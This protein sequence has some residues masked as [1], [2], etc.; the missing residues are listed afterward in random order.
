MKFSVSRK[1]I[2]AR[3]RTQR[4]KGVEVRGGSASTPT[5][6]GVDRSYVDSNLVTLSTEQVIFAIK[7]FA[8][9]VKIGGALIKY[10]EDLNAYVL[11]A[12][13]LVEGGVASFATPEGFDPPT[14][15][16]AVKVD[17]KT[18]S[19]ANGVLE[20]ISGVS[21]GG[22]DPDVDAV[23][24]Y[25]LG[26]DGDAGGAGLNEEELKAYLDANEYAQKSDIPTSLPAS[27]VYAWAKAATKPTYNYSEIQNTPTIP[28]VP[29]ELP[30]PAAL[31]WTA[32]NFNNSSKS[33]YYGDTQKT[34][35][36]PTSVSHLEGGTLDG[37]LAVNGHIASLST[38]DERL[39]KNIRDFSATEMLASMGGVYEYEY[40]AEEVE[41]NP[42]LVG[43]HHGFIY[44]NVAKSQMADMAIKRED[45][46]G[47]LNYLH[48]SYLA[49]LAAANLELMKR[50]EAL[51]KKLNEKDE[52]YGC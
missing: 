9:G 47:A 13:L 20:V 51:E 48:P 15:M 28:T 10:N 31:K 40:T 34:L 38:S 3:P 30:N 42:S 25:V 5:S 1:Y 24:F 29:T 45:G 21:G 11:P 32:G 23:A 41:R 12:N 43:T 18:I 36:I 46:Y 39:K 27:D 16:D 22:D 44:Q 8:N 17:E 19:K 7:D 6:S 14:I 33:P 49:L 52:N 37:D 2:E 4:R 35:Y 26:E 50:V